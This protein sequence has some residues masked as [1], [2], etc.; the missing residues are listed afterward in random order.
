MNR[1][2]LIVLVLSSVVVLTALAA[3]TPIDLAQLRQ[4][5]APFHNLDAAQQAGYH[6]VPGL[7]FCFDNLGVGGMGFHYIDTTELNN[8]TLNLRRPEALVY[9]PTPNGLQLAAVEY[10]VPQGLWDG[11][12]NTQPPSLNGVSLHLDPSLGVYILH[13]WVWKNNPA[14]I[15][16]DFNPKVSLCS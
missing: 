16:E 6:L 8:T 7:D 9:A 10:I 12:G 4:A 5:T 3:I 11:A 14:G 13:I 2:T 1:K 15:F